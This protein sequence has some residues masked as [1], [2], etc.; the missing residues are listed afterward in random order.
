MLYFRIVDPGL[1]PNLCSLILFAEY[2]DILPC[3]TQNAVLQVIR[4][5]HVVYVLYRF[6]K[7]VEGYEIGLKLL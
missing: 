7:I 6:R 1:S 5:I 4:L 2:S 3:Y